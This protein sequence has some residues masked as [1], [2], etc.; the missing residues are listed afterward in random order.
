MTFLSS[1]LAFIMSFFSIFSFGGFG[2]GGGVIGDIVQDDQADSSVSYYRPA[3]I[4]VPGRFTVYKYNPSD[5]ILVLCW[6]SQGENLYTANLSEYLK[7]CT[8]KS[9]ELSEDSQ[10]IICHFVY[11]TG[12]EKT[13]FYPVDYTELHIPG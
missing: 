1:I 7:G 10:Q 2:T 11:R 12:A 4:S 3:V 8:E 9:I 6:D 5:G 13:L